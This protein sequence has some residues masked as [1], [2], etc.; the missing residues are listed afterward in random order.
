[1]AVSELSSYQNDRS[2]RVGRFSQNPS[3][4]KIRF[5]RIVEVGATF[6]VLLLIMSGALIMRAVLYLP[7]GIS[8]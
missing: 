5:R 6:S 4:A 1:M 2:G 3:V 7:H 8:Q